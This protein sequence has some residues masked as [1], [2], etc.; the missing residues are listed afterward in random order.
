MVEV[1]Q[2]VRLPIC[3]VSVKN[4]WEDDNMA[5]MIKLFTV[6]TDFIAL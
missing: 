4:V 6:V 5:S 2:T 1:G 3:I